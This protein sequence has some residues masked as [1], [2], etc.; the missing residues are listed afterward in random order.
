MAFYLSE[1]FRPT[2]VQYNVAKVDNSRYQV[3]PSA[4]FMPAVTLVYCDEITS[5]T[6]INLTPPNSYLFSQ[7]LLKGFSP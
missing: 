5:A 4:R 1:G 6:V 3:H 2:T 7:R